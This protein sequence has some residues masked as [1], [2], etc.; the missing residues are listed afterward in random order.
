MSL[1]VGFIG[2]IAKGFVIE[3]RSIGIE[4]GLARGIER[5]RGRATERGMEK[6]Q[7]NVKEIAI[8]IVAGTE[9]TGTDIGIEIEPGTEIATETAGAEA[10]GTETIDGTGTESGSEI[11]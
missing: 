4:T 1:V 5:V 7:E 2:Q 8:V 10:Q 9:T 11:E 6:S 3:T